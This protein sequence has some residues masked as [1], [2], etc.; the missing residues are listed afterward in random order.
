MYNG[1]RVNRAEFTRTEFLYDVFEQPPAGLVY[2]ST[3][4]RTSTTEAI[5]QTIQINFLNQ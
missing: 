3:S 4:V 2:R 5:S 1:R